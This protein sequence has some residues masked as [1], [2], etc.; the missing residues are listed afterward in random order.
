MPRSAHTRIHPPTHNDT[1]RSRSKLPSLVLLVLLV[2][3]PATAQPPVRADR[4]PSAT[5]FTGGSTPRELSIPFSERD[6]QSRVIVEFNLQ[7]VARSSDSARSIASHEDLLS[8]FRSDMQRIGGMPAQRS[9]HGARILR[10]YSLTFSGAAVTLEGSALDALRS[11]PYV[12]RVSMDTEVRATAEPGIALIRADMVRSAFAARGVGITVAIIDTGID[13]GHPAL[14]GNFGPGFKVVGGWDFVNDDA[15]PIDDNGHGT[16][17]AGIVA[18]NSPELLGVAPD[19]QLFAYKVLDGSGYGFP[20]DAIAAIER[21]ADPD[22]NL[23]VSDRVDV[24]N[25]SLGRIGQGD[26]SLSDAV[27]NLVLLG[28]VVCVAAGDDRDWQ[29]IESPAN[30][31]EAITVG[32]IDSHSAIAEFSSRGPLS[33]TWALKPDV[34]A[35]GVGVRS[36]ALHGETDVLSGTSMASAYVAG[37]AALLRELHPDWTAQQIKSAITTSAEPLSESVMAAGSGRVDALRAASAETLV[38]PTSISFGRV[39]P[40]SGSWSSRR[41]LTVTNGSATNRSYAVTTSEESSGLIVSVS[42]PSFSLAAGGSIDLDVTATVNMNALAEP[43][44]ESL[45]YGGFV[46]IDDGYEPARVPYAVVRGV[47]VRL[48]YAGGGYPTA[49]ISRHGAPAALMH[50]RDGQTFERLVEPGIHDCV[51]MAS[52][53]PDGPTAIVAFENLDLTHDRELVASNESALYDIS[54]S[55][56]DENGRSLGSVTTSSNNCISARRIVLPDDPRGGVQINFIGGG[57]ANLRTSALNGRITIV[58]RDVC[59]D[60]SSSNFYSAQYD[61]LSVVSGP[62]ELHAGGDRYRVQPVEVRLPS[63]ASSPTLLQLESDFFV[64]GA[65]VERYALFVSVPRGAHRWRGT[66]FIDTPSNATFQFI[67]SVS[68]MT[69]TSPATRA[70]ESRGIRLTEL[71]ASCYDEPTRPPTAWETALGESMIF[72]AGSVIPTLEFKTT[73]GKLL[74]TAVSRGQLDETIFVRTA[75]LRHLSAT[76]ELLAEDNFQLDLGDPT[77]RTRIEYEAV[78]HELAGRSGITFMTSTLGATPADTLPPSLTSMIM[79]QEDGTRLLDRTR[80]GSAPLIRFSAIDVDREAAEVILRYRRTGSETWL[81]LPV[82]TTGYDYPSEGLGHEPR[83][84]SFEGELLE[85]ASSEG[86]YD[87]RYDLVDG[88][89]NTTTV[90]GTDAI[91]VTSERLRPVR[92]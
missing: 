49:V 11:L 59:F 48:S 55:S 13:Y 15:D 66:F 68:A 51:A 10:E 88:A 84:T 53:G 18:A 27:D 5:L 36:S 38:S 47:L 74:C 3:I 1:S 39:E 4:A 37:V 2:A 77:V 7:P 43:D 46:T 61:P 58:G 23:D 40:S 64:G 78:T 33:S 86:M 21:C 35:P 82:R 24:V 6:G 90:I 50:S 60:E 56:T 63:G 70:M 71:G 81:D 41:T 79:V 44:V 29:S 69:D 83:G 54:F 52:A 75:K 76:G 34:V 80:A 57:E 20:S 45:T 16:H 92:R 91:L 19:A 14:G 22:G 89:G 26:D 42:S 12:K 17:V 30:A 87:L 67:P 25:L 72:D 85:L 9:S 65:K 31:S 28:S 62:V 8:R 73:N 32:A